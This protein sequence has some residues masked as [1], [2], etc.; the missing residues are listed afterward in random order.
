MKKYLM[1]LL[2]TLLFAGVAQ[3]QKSAFVPENQIMKIQKGSKDATWNKSESILKDSLD[4]AICKK[5]A[6]KVENGELQNF[7]TEPLV[8]KN[9]KGDFLVSF[10]YKFDSDEGEGDFFICAPKGNLQKAIRIKLSNVNAE[11]GENNIG[12]I[13]GKIAPKG[14]FDEP[15]G[16]W[17]KVL[18][19]VEGENLRLSQGERICVHYADR[20]FLTL[21]F[22]EISKKLGENFSKD[23]N[24]GFVCN[25][26]NIKIK[27]VSVTKL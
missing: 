18:V 13:N 6:W 9:L 26:G 27:N 10:E 21:S 17:V 15:K 19:F 2:A 14:K 16:R 23:G 3:A 25:N 5:D 11:K 22:E 1:I 8:I 7:G 12:S 4:A 24:V 20:N